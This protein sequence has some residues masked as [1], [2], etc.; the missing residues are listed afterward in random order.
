MHIILPETTICIFLF[1]GTFNRH[2]SQYL[3]CIQIFVLSINDTNI[4][5]YYTF[6]NVCDDLKYLLDNV[7]NIIGTKI[8]RQFVGITTGTYY[9]SLSVADVFIYLFSFIF[10]LISSRKH[11]YIMLTPLYPTFYIV[12]LGFT[13]VY[14]IFRI[15][16]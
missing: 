14:I 11:T 4:I 15:Y 5:L 7:S 16:A 6:Q 3:A 1:E 13:R 10:L 2:D 9:C 12:K 8:F